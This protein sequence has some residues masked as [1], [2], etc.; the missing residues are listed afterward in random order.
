MLAQPNPRKVDGNVADLPQQCLEILA[1]GLLEP[2]SEN[3]LQRCP[4]LPPAFAI[5]LQWYAEV[6]PLLQWW[7]Q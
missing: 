4:G 1:A 2:L 5:T 3:L 6:S 7:A